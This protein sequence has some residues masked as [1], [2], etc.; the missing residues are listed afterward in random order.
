MQKLSNEQSQLIDKHYFSVLKGI[1][2][3][4]K[5]KR[6][7]NIAMENKETSI[8][9]CVSYIVEAALSWKPEK[10]K[11]GNFVQFAVNRCKNRYIDECRKHSENYREYSY[12]KQHGLSQ[13]TK[14]LVTMSESF[15]KNLFTKSDNFSDIEHREYCQN[16]ID[17]SEKFFNNRSNHKSQ[18]HKLL[19]K[20][21]IV[22]KL[23]NKSISLAE[24]ANKIGINR[25]NAYLI[26]KSKKMRKFINSLFN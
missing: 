21:Y 3:H 16:I 14:H 7:K 8:L 6:Y 12:N 10:S 15:C 4:F 13:E 22:P 20:E 1:K 5:K 17:K 26:I 24:A 11:T 23:S 9:Q 19:I 25:N 2:N 18:L